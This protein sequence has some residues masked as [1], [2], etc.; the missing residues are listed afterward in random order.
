MRS[1]GRAISAKSAAT[2]SA[3]DGKL[4]DA[5]LAKLYTIRRQ[6]ISR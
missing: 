5:V 4:P 1:A 6:E 3:R 2:P